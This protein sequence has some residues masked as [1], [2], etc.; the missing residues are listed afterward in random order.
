MVDIARAPKPK[1]GRYVLYGAGAVA[2]I[3]VTI[4][5]AKLKPAAPTVER[6]I[7]SIDSVRQG[8]MIRDVRGPGTL[9]PE[10]IRRVVA[11]N[12]ARI[13]RIVAQVGQQVTPE[14]ILL[15]MSNPDVD[16]AAMQ[17]QQ[18]Y[19][20]ARSTLANMR[21][22]LQRGLL[23]QQTTVAAAKTN[24]VTAQQNAV[25]AESMLSKHFLSMAE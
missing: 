14:T 25:E 12:S 6:S 15:E 7:I 20:D 19:G 11:L 18:T 1:T 24:N 8:D 5:V 16:I 4:L 3:I 10:H 22:T 9:V 23:Q 13:D 21:V 17:A 2:V